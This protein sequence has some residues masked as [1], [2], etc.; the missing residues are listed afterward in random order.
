MGWIKN[1][2]IGF[3]FMMRNLENSLQAKR[4]EQRKILD[5]IKK[6]KKQ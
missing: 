4:D 3:G 1:K 6:K 2:V 5:D